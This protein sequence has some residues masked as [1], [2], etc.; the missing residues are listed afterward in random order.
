MADK[1]I[2]NIPDCCIKTGNQRPCKVCGRLT[3]YVEYC[4]EMPLCSNECI[5]KLYEELFSEN[6]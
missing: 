5:S 2:E 1:N 3:S 6:N 4:F